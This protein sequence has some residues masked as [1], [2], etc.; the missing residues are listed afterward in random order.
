M[1]K[2]KIRAELEHFAISYTVRRVSC[3]EHHP[4]QAIYH[5]GGHFVRTYEISEDA[6]SEIIKK[7][8]DD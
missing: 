4:A 2:N 1:D 6:L 8:K 3:D 7:L 5:G